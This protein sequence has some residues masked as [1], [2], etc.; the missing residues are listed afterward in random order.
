MNEKALSDDIQVIRNELLRKM[1]CN[2]DAYPSM[3]EQEISPFAGPDC[4]S[5]GN[6]ST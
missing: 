2:S 4:R 1:G 5:V 6:A 3:I